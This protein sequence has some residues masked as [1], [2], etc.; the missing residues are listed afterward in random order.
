MLC[1]FETCILFSDRNGFLHFLLAIAEIILCLQSKSVQNQLFI[2]EDFQQI[3][4]EQVSSKQTRKGTNNFAASRKH[5]AMHEKLELCVL[6]S[7]W[8]RIT[9]LNDDHKPFRAV[10]CESS[11]GIDSGSE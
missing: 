11:Q 4:P 5:H 7:N 1:P 8:N 6:H 10:L 9:R 2:S 3:V